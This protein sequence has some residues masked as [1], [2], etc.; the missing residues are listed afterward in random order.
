MNESLMRDLEEAKHK[1]DCFNLKVRE[2]DIEHTN[3]SD[4]DKLS[5]LFNHVNRGIANIDDGVTH[6]DFISF[7]LNTVNVFLKRIENV[8]EKYIQED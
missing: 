3:P 2:F 6:K 4:Y 8:L 5:C 7:E 1:R